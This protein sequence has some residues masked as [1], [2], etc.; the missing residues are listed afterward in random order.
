MKRASILVLSISAILLICCEATNPDAVPTEALTLLE[1][2]RSKMLTTPTHKY[3][4]LSFWDN[5]FASSTYEDTMEITYSWLPDSERG[6][7]FHAV[8]SDSEILYDGQDELKIDHNK[9]KVVRVTAAEI[10]KDSAYFANKMC[11]HGDPKILPEAADIDRI[12][13]TIIGGKKLYAY[14]ITANAPSVGAGDK[15]F[16]ATR[17]YYLDP[18]QQVVARI[19]NVSHVGR[20]TSQVIDYFFRD[21]AFTG[22]RHEFG[23]SDRAKSLTYRE[24]NKSEDQ[25]ERRS[26]LIRPGAQLYRADYISIDGKEELI[27]GKTG[28][29]TVVMFGFI[30]CS[31]CAYALR[32]MKKKSFSVK[33]GVELVY[34]SPVDGASTLENYLEKKEFPFTSFGKDSR[35]NDNF[36]VA[37]FPTFVL[38]NEQGGVERVIGEYDTEVAEILFE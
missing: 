14:S 12:T 18:E 33:G 20:D 8:G 9:R 25:T 34:S 24:I 2:T 37:G 6:F 1:A 21:Y 23:A 31:G 7:G 22:E 27:Y 26:G 17:V 15:G 38:I 35:M 13:D 32:E 19:R 30:G 29:K 10:A 11:F 16:V 5:R 4:F 28:K 3:R 36:K